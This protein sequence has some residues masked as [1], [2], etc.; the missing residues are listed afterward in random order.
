MSLLDRLE[1]PEA[2]SRAS[3]SPTR[4]PR[5]AAS[6]AAP[7]PV[8]PPPITSTSSGPAVRFRIASS[9]SRASRTPGIRTAPPRPREGPPPPIVCNRCS[10]SI[11]PPAPSRPA[12]PTQPP[13][14]AGLACLQLD[15]VD[16]LPAAFL[17]QQRG[18][19]ENAHTGQRGADHEPRPEAGRERDRGV[20]PGRGRGGGAGDDGR[21]DRQAER[22]AELAADVEQGR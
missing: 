18:G 6:S 12:R 3:T 16:P 14:P 9:R 2:R 13:C 21:Y 17:A 15:Q 1:V 22:A 5:E 20:V 10:Q 11:A 8:M 4:R 7:A 19:R